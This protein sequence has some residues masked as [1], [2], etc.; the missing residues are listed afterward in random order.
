MV[1]IN[2]FDGKEGTFIERVDYNVN[3]IVKSLKDGNAVEI[4]D[5]K[6][7]E[8][9]ANYISFYFKTDQDGFASLY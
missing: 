7:N 2:I 9:I 5:V 1:K 4:Y 6:S 8:P 3:K